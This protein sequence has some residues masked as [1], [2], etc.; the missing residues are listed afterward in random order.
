MC[1]PQGV[2]GSAF[3][4]PFTLAGP[5]TKASHPAYQSLTLRGGHLSETSPFPRPFSVL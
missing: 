2:C 4:V 3:H 1:V 5:D